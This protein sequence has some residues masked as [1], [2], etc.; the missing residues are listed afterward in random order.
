MSANLIEM[1]IANPNL[2]DVARYVR[3]AESLTIE[4]PADS[5]AAQEV[6]ASVNTQLKTLI[7]QR[8]EITRP[9]DEAKKKVMDLFRPIT[10]A[11]EN[12]IRVFDRKII[13]WDNEQEEIR[14]KAQRDEEIAAQA[15]RDRLQEI[16][17]R[18]LA[19]GQDGKAEKF[20]ERAQ[21]IVA[22]V[23]PTEVVRAS[24]VSVASRWT[25]EI[26]DAKKIE[27]LFL[28]PDLVAIGKVVRAMG[29]EAQSVVGAG[30]RIIESKS[31]ASRRS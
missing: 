10:T 24:G 5:I 17:D 6:R 3:A 18:A 21:S 12:A 9:M 4:F 8:L 27:P 28:A 29:K 26:I 16:S 22:N 19:Q 30:V 11:L 7:D 20:Q 1:K 15:E 13:Q 2:P 31:V 25:F 14:K 23:I